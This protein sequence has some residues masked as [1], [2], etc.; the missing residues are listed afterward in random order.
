MEKAVLITGASSG[1][2]L[3]SAEQLHRAGFMIFAGY[4]PGEDVQALRKVAAERLTLIPI[5]VTDHETVTQAASLVAEATG[6]AGLYGLVNNAGI[7]VAGPMEYLPLDALRQQMEVNY[8][9]QVAVTQAFLPLV[10]QARGRIVNICS[11]LGRMTVPFNGAYCASK[12]AMEAFTDTLRLE[13]QPWGIQVIGIEPGVIK[14]RIWEAGVQ[15]LDALNGTLPT[16]ARQQYEKQIN[17]ANRAVHRLI[18][19]ATPP[20]EVADRV[21]RA[22]TARRPRARYVV[23][24]EAWLAVTSA[25]LLPERLL[26]AILRRRYDL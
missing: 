24:R 25:R 2:G 10:R 13:L 12:F 14:T 18:E 16:E 7:A 15:G 9:G 19:S 26:D 21:V 3:A 6:T 23:G 20:E 8:I 1:I 17:A 5:D 4:L 22:L 11:F